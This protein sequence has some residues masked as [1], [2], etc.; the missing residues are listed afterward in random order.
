MLPRHFSS[1]VKGND[2]GQGKQANKDGN[3]IQPAHQLN[4]AKYKAV[5]AINQIKANGRKNEAKRR[6]TKSL[7]KLV[8]G[9]AGDDGERKQDKGENLGRPESKR[10]ACQ[11]AGKQDQRYVREEVGDT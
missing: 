7:E 10:K 11:H 8:A 5:G 4:L 2:F 9:Y 3:E 1:A 6:R